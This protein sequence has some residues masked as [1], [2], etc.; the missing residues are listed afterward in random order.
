MLSVK[1]LR[2][3][4]DA[5]TKPRI[6]TLVKVSSRHWLA[7]VSGAIS[8]KREEMHRVT[9]HQGA[10]ARRNGVIRLTDRNYKKEQQFV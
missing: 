6:H 2:P 4:Y 5:S 1:L 9:V 8:N 10:L 7:G 3:Y